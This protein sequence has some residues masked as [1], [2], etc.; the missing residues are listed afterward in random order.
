MTGIARKKVLFLTDSLGLPRPNREVLASQTWGHLVASQ[1]C[2]KYDFYFQFFGGLHT[3]KLV[4]ERLYGYLAGYDPDI[5]VL[6]IGIVD[7]S[8]RVL[9][10]GEK[11]FLSRLPFVRNYIRIFISKYHAQL[12]NIRKLTY[13]TTSEFEKNLRVIKDSFPNSEIIVIPI[14]PAN[15]EYKLMAPKIVNNI[16]Q[17]NNILENVFGD[18]FLKKTYLGIDVKTLFLSDHHHLS[19]LGHI[20]LAEIIKEKLLEC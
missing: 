4:L 19:V 13:T 16:Y 18:F 5:V 7:C 15:R 1:L 6:Q 17:Y 14:A 10:N 3:K 12:S 11:W 9:R 2:R 8:P 20:H